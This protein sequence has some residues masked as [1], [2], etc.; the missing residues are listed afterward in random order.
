M[1]CEFLPPYSPDFNP[2]ELALSDVKDCLR[3]SSQSP[4]LCPALKFLS[5]WW[6]SK[7]CHRRIDVPRILC[8][9]ISAS[10]RHESQFSSAALRPRRISA[11]WVKCGLLFASVTR[12]DSR[13]SVPLG[14]SP[15][16]AM[17]T[18]EGAIVVKGRTCSQC[19]PMSEEFIYHH[20][21][22][23][24]GLFR[25]P[26]RKK[27]HLDS[28]RWARFADPSVRTSGCQGIH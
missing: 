18:A 12:T 2:V 19:T 21:A 17:T 5:L 9:L 15:L 3:P 6:R 24:L 8:L 22:Q 1:R 4:R 13:T 16:N 20:T 10:L 11:A 25:I 27:G 7:I 28:T 14:S 23:P 26:S